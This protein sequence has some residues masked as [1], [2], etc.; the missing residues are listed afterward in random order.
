MR[1]ILIIFIFFIFSFCKKENILDCFTSNGKEITETR[2]VSDF[3]FIEAYDDI[4]VNILKGKDFKIEIIAGE[5]IIHK[6]STNIENRLLK[7]KNLNSCNFVRGYDRKIKVNITLPY[8]K[9]IK[10]LGVGNIIFDKNFYE[11]TIFVRI[12]NSGD[13]YL[14]GNYNLIKTSSHGNGNVFLN[15]TCNSLY[16][17]LN[18]TNFIYAEKL[19]VL[20]YIFIETVSIGDCFISA[21]N[22]NTLEYNIWSDGNIFYRGNP[23][24]IND[25]SKQTA[26][27][28]LIQLY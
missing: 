12:E 17:Y 2:L 14:N 18:G 11:D 7:I 20:D 6:V 3:D 23:K 1:N 5:N 4:E 13:V 19:I 16:S 27:G 15:G 8:L 10:N 25:F 28:K 21:L 26:N 9:I 24:F 22:C